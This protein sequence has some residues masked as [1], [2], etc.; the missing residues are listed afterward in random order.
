MNPDERQRPTV[1]EVIAGWEQDEEP[2]ESHRSFYQ[3]MKEL[4]RPCRT[5]RFRG[6]PP[7]SS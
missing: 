5:P 7:E 3:T 6:E 2:M 4:F 1:D